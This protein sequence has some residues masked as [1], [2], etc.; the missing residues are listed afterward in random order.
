MSDMNAHKA[1]LAAVAEV[2]SV[3]KLGINDTQEYSYVRES[4]V[5]AACRPALLK[6][7]LLPL[8]SL[9]H[10]SGPDQ[11][12]NTTVSGKLAFVHPQSGTSVEIDVWG[13][14]NDRY[15]LP[16]GSV[17]VGDKGLYK[18]MAGAMKYGLLIAFSLRKDAE[19]EQPN[20]IDARAAKAPVKKQPSQQPTQP[21]TTTAPPPAPA[22][23]QPAIDSFWSRFSSS[24]PQTDNPYAEA[25]QYF[26][27]FLNGLQT[28]EEVQSYWDNNRDFLAFIKKSDASVY[29]KIRDAVQAYVRHLSSQGEQQ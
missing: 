24:P 26:V 14:G 16:D 7:G 20:A 27:E 11:H 5:I 19:P 8:M 28:K 23:A 6:H 22:A 25:A 18:A 13:C 9:H 17:A 2:S 15:W 1:L 3:G 21:Q 29:N 12:G 10:A 4:D